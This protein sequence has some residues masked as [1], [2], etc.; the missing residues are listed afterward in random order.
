MRKGFALVLTIVVLIIASVFAVAVLTNLSAHVKTVNLEST[1][2]FAQLDAQNILQ[3]SVAFIRPKFSGIRGVTLNW[4]SASVAERVNWWNSFKNW[5]FSQSDG[6]FWKNFFQRVDENRYFDVSQIQ[7]FSQILRQYGLNC[8]SVVLPITGSYMVGGN[9]YSVLVVSKGNRGKVESY[10]LAV[11]A[12]DFLNKY[13]Y[14][15]EKEIRPGGGPIYFISREVVDGPLR[16]NDTI[17][18]SGNPTFKS[19]VE[20]KDVVIQRGTPNFQMGWYRLTQQ[21][22]EDYNMNKI[23]QNY[24]SDL[25]VLVTDMRSFLS[26]SGEMGI[27]L[28]LEG[29]RIKV[30]NNVRTAQKLIVEFKSAQGQGNDHF[31]KVYVEYKEGSRIGTD[32]LFTIKPHND[33]QKIVI[34][35]ENARKWLGIEDLQVEEKTINFNGVLLCDLTIALKN[36]SNSDKPMYV[37][38]K[39]T[40]YSKKDVEIYDHIVYED[41]RDLLPHNTIDRIVIDENLVQQM[42]NATRTDFLNIVANGYVRVMEKQKNLKITASIYSFDESF[43]VKN[44]NSGAPAGQLT[45]FG[46][47]MQN[48]RGPVG[49]FSGDTVQTGYYKNYIYDYKILEGFSAIGTPAK[50]EG[51]VLLAI[52]GLY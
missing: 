35:G 49:T 6:D 7:E 12:V 17:Y 47:L 14:F 50:R 51:V 2:N 44:Y 36:N 38:G 5:L 21:D 42:R 19:A 1:R 43:E 40:I 23:K 52:R 10:A 11:L 45:I 39:Y 3:L 8:A 46:S 15:T 26:S 24:A 30:G 9:P 27:K 16:S 29:K 48:Y 32:A 20:V 4:V 28:N 37:D 18:I 34:H 13:A 25:E 41:F 33:T 22:I 31:M